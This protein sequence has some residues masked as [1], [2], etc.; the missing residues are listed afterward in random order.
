MLNG[1]RRGLRL[2]EVDVGG[3]LHGRERRCWDMMVFACLYAPE[4][5]RSRSVFLVW[6]HSDER[7]LPFTVVAPRVGRCLSSQ[8]GCPLLRGAV[9][10]P[11]FFIV[12]CFLSFLEFWNRRSQGQQGGAVRNTTVG[13]EMTFSLHRYLRASKQFFIL[14]V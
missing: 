13:F 4:M 6:L 9:R 12:N 7:F 5:R 2:E 3:R 14:V 10:C 8:L 1:R 11:K